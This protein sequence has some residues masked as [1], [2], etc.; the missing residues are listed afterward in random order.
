V[1]QGEWREKCVE[2]LKKNL[3]LNLFEWEQ[4]RLSF[5]KDLDAM[6]FRTRY[7]TALAGAIFFLITQG[8][9]F[10]TDGGN[11]VTWVKDPVMGWVE[12]TTNDF[13]QYVALALFLMLLYLS[14]VQTHQSLKRFKDCVDLLILDLKR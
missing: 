8:I 14:G 10:I 11:R 6:L 12:L 5:E 13:N 9:D 2:H 4:I 7:L 1:S 3:H